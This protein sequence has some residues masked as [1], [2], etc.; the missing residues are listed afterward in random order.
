MD[1]SISSTIAFRMVSPF[2]AKMK[3]GMG[4]AGDEIQGWY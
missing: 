4:I 3:A 1:M 2:V